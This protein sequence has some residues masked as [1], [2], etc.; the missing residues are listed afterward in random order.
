M[1]QAN[2]H[3][4]NVICICGKLCKN[5]RGLKI[6]KARMKCLDKD[7][8]VQ[9]SGLVPGETQEEPGQEATHR[10]QSLHVPQTLNPSRV[11]PQQRI[12]WPP[13]SKRSEWQQ[14]DEDVSKIIQATAKGDVDS[15]LTSMTTIIISY[16]SERF[17]QVDKGKSKST[18]YTMSRRATRIHHLRQEL[19]T[20][21]KQ[22]KA[23][24][25]EEKKPL[26]ELKNILR[27]KL[28]TLRRAEWHRRRAKERARKRAAF[29]AN[30]FGFTKQLLGDKRS[31]QLECSIEQVN[32]FL[33]DT[34]SDPQRDLELE[35]NK[36]LIRPDLPTMEFNLKEPSLKEVEEVV[37]AARSASAP[38]PSGTPYLV[39]KRCP[40]LLRHLWKILKVIWRRGKVADQWRHAEGVWIPKEENSR[41]ISQFRTISL[42][43]VE[44]KVF[45]SI[46]SRRL[47]EFLLK[48]SYI[49]PSVQKGGISAPGCLE[50]TGVVTQ[51]IREAHEN[52]GDL[53]VLWLDLAN[54]YG[55]IPHK[56]VELA[57]HLHH[58][59]SK[60]KDLILDYY[61][62]FRM[63]VT[64]GSETSDWHSIEKGIITG[65]TI[66]VVLFSLAMNMVVKSAE[67]ECRGPLT[68]S[69]VRQ[70]PIRAFMDDLTV[71]TTSVPGCRWILQ[72]LE[73]LM[74]WARM[75]FKPSKSRSM[76]LK[77]GK[78][79]D[80]FRFSISGTVIPTITEQ[81]VKSLGKLFD[82]T[83]KD[84]A[85]IQKA[86]LEL[87]TW[88][89][90]VDKS[91]L[92]GRFKAWIYQHSILPRILW[93]LL[94]YAVPMTAVES[95]ERRISSFLRKWLGLPRSLTSAALYGT[96]NILQLPLRGLTEEFMVAR[97][98]EALQYRDSK[99]SKVSAAG[100]EVRTGR[101]WKAREAVKL[102][103]SRLR[104]KEL[105][106]TEATGR[107]GLGYFPKI[108]ISQT[109]GKE[110]HHLIQEEVRA[111]VEE[112]RLSRV[113]G[114]RQQGAWT[115]WES[116]LK[117]RI[118]WTNILQPDFQRVR[119]LVQAV[120]DVL[121]SPANLH[122]WGKSE[123]P[124]CPLCSGRGSL[125]HLLSGCPKALAD[126]RY[127]WRHDQ[128]LKA[129]AE[130]VASA[131][132]SSKN[133][134]A[135]KKAIYFVKAGE[136]PRTNKHATAGLLHTASDWQLQ[137]DL[138]K[139]MRFPQQIATTTLRPDMIMTSQS[140]KQLIILELT[141][142]WEENIEEANERK[143]AKYQE[144]VEECRGGGW[145]TFYEPIEVGCRGFAGRSLCKVLSRL[146]IV[147]AA[148]KR[149][150]K[151]ASEAAE[152]ATRWLWMKRADPWVATGTQ[153]GA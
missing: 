39:Y 36:A 45:F 47:T 151:S 146:G 42:L 148:K 65:C 111:G 58:V 125:E 92:P 94:I 6:H 23:A 55:S 46:V 2:G 69:G 110:R 14:F 30:P 8:E 3:T 22:Y 118:T 76:V 31:G 145:K 117:R 96:S 54:A 119:F 43:S 89:T 73:K 139:Q 60:I 81:P 102:A 29:I 48:N 131:I 63:R 98:R 77:K 127:R 126:G 123:T 87:G 68:K 100:I 51:L 16:A 133:H 104:Q 59:P 78:V 34:V 21:K 105:V 71:T 106:G 5:H 53:A 153:V 49:D 85:A 132:S 115:R 134:H 137:V 13:A 67:V 18:S 129:V 114:L 120:Y 24:A 57:L 33:Q 61:N 95:L 88:L 147:G 10:A 40:G 83:L 124:S 150:I 128:V 50:H 56:L 109:R 121:P 135:P 52:K 38:G 17:G 15:R 44:G 116:A 113:V 86:S 140:S 80:K 64:S 108:L 130:S 9:R 97:T 136:K 107:A 112:E 35:P 28:M 143:R 66:S 101:K 141:V 20:L 41:D 99:D 1:T 19:R 82:S 37:K 90:K 122:V 75:S 26:L 84:S 32:H 4:T 62:K 93:P 72:G 12:K 7:N 79:I 25:E 74:T 152:K 91:G 103:E 138:G 70:P 11:I 144:L 142:P 27:K 149:A